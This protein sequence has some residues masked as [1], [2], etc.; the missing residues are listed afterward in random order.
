MNITERVDNRFWNP[1]VNQYL[2]YPVEVSIKISS[3]SVKAGEKL[4]AKTNDIRFIR[5]WLKEERE[6][7]GR[8][9]MLR[10]LE[11]RLRQL[12]GGR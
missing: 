12:E 9:T 4:I 8:I 1:T 3:K 10:L 11:D 2:T 6:N 5:A 7:K